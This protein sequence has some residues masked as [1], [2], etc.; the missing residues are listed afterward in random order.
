MTENPKASYWLRM[1]VQDLWEREPEAALADA[2]LLVEL[3]Q[4]KVQA[5]RLL[6]QGW[7]KGKAACTTSSYDS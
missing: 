1:A 3:L 4:L 6:R 7:G 2:A 5:D